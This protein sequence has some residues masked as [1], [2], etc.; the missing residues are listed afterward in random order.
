LGAQATRPSAGLPAQAQLSDALASV[1]VESR[2]GVG[3]LVG[4]PTFDPLRNKRFL[5]QVFRRGLLLV[6]TGVIVEL[7]ILLVIAIFSLI[8]GF[9]ALVVLPVITTL[10]AI[11]LFLIFILLPVPAMLSY[12]SKLVS[13]EA[14]TAERAFELIAAALDRHAIPRDAYQV[15]GIPLPG[16]GRRDY[17]E[18]RRSVFT[19]Y[20]SCFPHGQDMYMS[21]TFWI[22][23]SPLRLG[24]MRI[25]RLIQTLQG[26]GNDLY[27][28]LRYESIRA[29]VSAID[30]CT[31]EGI[32][33]ALAEVHG[34]RAYSLPSGQ[35]VPIS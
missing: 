21:W 1:P 10:T 26:R 28:T 20:I 17:I 11:A 34:E 6:L 4:E 12:G 16:E 32:D 14:R 2:R 35:A 13:Y 18:L 5:W 3:D 31:S 7:V 8:A 23:M 9:A 25:G 24:L 27:Q 22:Y 30:L 15:R 19:A 33:A 29:T